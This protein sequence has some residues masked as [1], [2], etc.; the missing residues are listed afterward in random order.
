MHN[1]I[2]SFDWPMGT[3]NKPS[4]SIAFGGVEE[5]KM[6]SN[7]GVIPNDPTGNARGNLA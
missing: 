2:P 4:K 5:Y 1:L 7:E 3:D 6:C